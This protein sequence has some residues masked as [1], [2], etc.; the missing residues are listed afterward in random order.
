M[1]FKLLMTVALLVTYGLAYAEIYVTVGEFGEVSYSDEAS[2]GAA[3]ID[4]TTRE[5]SPDDLARAAANVDRTWDLARDMEASRLAR[6]AAVAARRKRNEP[7]PQQQPTYQAPRVIVGY[8]SRDQTSIVTN[9][10]VDRVFEPT[11][12]RISSACSSSMP[13]PAVRLSG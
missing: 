3:L 6:E 5:P 2:P 13:N 1:K 9:I 12:E 4:L 8:G 10:H 11:K 7:E